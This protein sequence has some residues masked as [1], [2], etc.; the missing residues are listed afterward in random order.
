MCLES[1]PRFARSP[2]R[3]EMVVEGENLLGED[4]SSDGDESSVDFR[5]AIGGLHDVV[6][7]E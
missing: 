7:C 1:V 3:V 2:P 6:G 5:R 4:G